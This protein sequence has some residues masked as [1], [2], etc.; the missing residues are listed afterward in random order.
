MT[1]AI[2]RPSL[3]NRCHLTPRRCRV[4][5]PKTSR[6]PSGQVLREA[7]GVAPGIGE[8]ERALFGLGVWS[9]Y[10]MYAAFGV[11]LSG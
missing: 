10:A 6:R 11:P 2:C 7:P 1:T 8:G 4:C 9:F 3:P 5:G